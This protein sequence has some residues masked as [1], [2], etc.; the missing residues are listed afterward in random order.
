[1]KG[2]LPLIQTALADVFTGIRTSD[3]FLIPDPDIIPNGTRFPCI[4]IKDGKVD[5]SE[6]MGDVL[7]KT[8]PAEI[9]YYDRLTPGDTCILDFLEKGDDINVKLKE[10][11][12]S[13]YV[14]STSPRSETPI[15]IMYTK[16]GLILRRGLFY[17]YEREG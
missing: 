8:L 11:Y 17:Q 12:L 2:L 5:I 4:G 9:Y 15:K 3:I 7:E 1:M 6:L 14:K 13:G 16:K 10:N